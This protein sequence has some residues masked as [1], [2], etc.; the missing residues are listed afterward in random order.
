MFLYGAR[1][2]ESVIA[3]SNSTEVVFGNNAGEDGD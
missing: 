1:W 3:L 2:R